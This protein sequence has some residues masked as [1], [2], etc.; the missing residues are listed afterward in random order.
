MNERVLEMERAKS[1]ALRS[2]LE[3][4]VEVSRRLSAAATPPIN[5]TVARSEKSGET[6]APF[7]SEKPERSSEVPTSWG[8]PALATPLS[9]AA[10]GDR[11]E[12]EMEVKWEDGGGQCSLEGEAGGEGSGQCALEGDTGG[13]QSSLAGGG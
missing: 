8:E 11:Q 10:S 2:M 6:P 1:A 9:S 5:I 4:L 3:Q 7:S 13:G 12:G